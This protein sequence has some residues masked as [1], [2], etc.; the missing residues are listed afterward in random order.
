V[1]NLVGH[2]FLRIVWMDQPERKSP[3]N[4]N[5]SAASAADEAMKALTQL[6]SSRELATKVHFRCGV[7]GPTEFNIFFESIGDDLFGRD[8]STEYKRSGSDLVCGFA[9]KASALSAATSRRN[10]PGGDRE[11]Y[12][13]Q[14]KGPPSL[15]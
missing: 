5:E 6:F 12:I 9:K 1:K 14:P 7:N 11:I 3:L 2:W 8:P 15:S 4:D 13:E 10:H